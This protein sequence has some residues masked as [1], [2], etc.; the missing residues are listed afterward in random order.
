MIRYIIE[1]NINYTH[2]TGV[3]TLMDG[4]NPKTFVSEKAALEWLMSND[5][6][7]CTLPIIHLA[8]YYTIKPYVI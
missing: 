1:K 2:G 4:E 5:E 7:F 6:E 8:D 3:V